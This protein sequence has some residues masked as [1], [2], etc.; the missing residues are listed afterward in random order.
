MLI[1][2]YIH[3][4]KRNSFLK[5]C[6]TTLGAL[7]APVITIAKPVLRRVGEGFF[8]GAGKDRADA[9]LTLFEGDTF[10]SKISTSDTDGSLYVFESSRVKPGGPPL[11]VHPDQDEWWYIL[12][13]QFKIKVGDR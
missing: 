5:E 6:I 9:P 10:Y 1:N 4:M 3:L 2:D 11:H 12:Q 8:V 13:G 7:A